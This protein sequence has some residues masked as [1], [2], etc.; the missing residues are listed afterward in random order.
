MPVTTLPQVMLTKNV[1]RHCQM[2]PQGTEL[3][4]VENHWESS[5]FLCEIIFLQP[6]SNSWAFS[7]P[8][9]CWWNGL[10]GFVCLKK[11]HFSLLFLRDI[12]TGCKI[13][14][15]HCFPRFSR[16]HFIVLC[17]ALFLRDISGNTYHCSCISL[18][19]SLTTFKT[20]IS[21]QQ[22]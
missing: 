5:M 13:L 1:S 6:K 16:C 20:V 12:F 21:S 2:F 17:I 22:F 11:R 4:T 10:S 15:P 7:L 9:D 14:C 3:S 8:E 18:P 19:F